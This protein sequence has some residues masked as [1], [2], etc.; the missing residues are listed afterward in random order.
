MNA[1]GDRSRGSAL[2][3]REFEGNVDVGRGRFVGVGRVSR[4]GG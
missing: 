1:G 3:N 4:T 2:S